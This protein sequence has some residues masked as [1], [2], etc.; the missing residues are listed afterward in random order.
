MVFFAIAFVQVERGHTHIDLLLDK[1]PKIVQK[2]IMFLSYLLGCAV[3]TLI[4]W[5]SFVLMQQK[6]STLAKAGSSRT[7]FV[8]WPF[9]VV[10]FVGFALLAVAMLW[11]A[12]REWTVPV[13]ERAGY[14]AP[15]TVVFEDEE[16]EE[17]G[18][19]EE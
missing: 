12:I 11:S 13:E 17:E 1:F 14:L 4:S 16:E 18:G 10:V 15:E 6:L 9:A 3:S 7:S 2:V 5:R 8:V 19:V